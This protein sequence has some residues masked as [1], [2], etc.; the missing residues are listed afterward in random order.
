MAFEY[1]L[2]RLMKINEN[3]KQQLERHYQI[4]YTKLED[5]AE[6]LIE[7]MKKKEQVHSALYKETQTKVTASSIHERLRYMEII[8]KK[9]E[10]EQQN[11]YTLKEK[12]AAFR[13]TLTDKSIEVKKH[14][15]LKET[16]YHQH[17]VME[18][19]SEMKQMDEQGQRIRTY[20]ANNLH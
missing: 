11:Y 19:R 18:K 20:R 2:E 8:E 13:Q 5:L 10:Q 1:R 17:L 6:Q 7:L 4:L 15:V 3:E 14:E 16:A 12:V 9:I